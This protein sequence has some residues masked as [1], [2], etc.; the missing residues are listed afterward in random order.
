MPAIG[1][2]RGV[3]GEID[4]QSVRAG[5]QIQMVAGPQIATLSANGFMPAGVTS[6]SVEASHC[7]RICDA[8]HPG[9]RAYTKN[10]TSGPKS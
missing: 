8:G 1:Q 5:T 3:A 6:K 2:Q 10:C 9:V 4:R 7:A